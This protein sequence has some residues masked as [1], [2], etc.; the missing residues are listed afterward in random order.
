MTMFKD[1]CV[2]Y[3]QENKERLQKWVREQVNKPSLK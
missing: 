2:K 1:L 3:N